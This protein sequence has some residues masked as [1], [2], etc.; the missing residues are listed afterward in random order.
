MIQPPSFLLYIDAGSGSLLIQFIVA[1][2]ASLAIAFRHKIYSVKTWLAKRFANGKKN[3]P[4]A[5]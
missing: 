3:G 5:K 1:G 4:D 2:I